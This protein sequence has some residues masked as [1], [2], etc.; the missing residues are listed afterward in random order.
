MQIVIQEVT[1]NNVKNGKGGYWVAEVTYSAN[2]KNSTKKIFSFANP[3]VYEVMSKAVQG[4]SY[5]VELKKNGEYWDWVAVKSTESA[6]VK[7]KPDVVP[8]KVI[9]SNY[10]TTEERKLRQLLIVRQSS[11]SNAIDF[12]KAQGTQEFQVMEVLGIAQQFVDFV[13]GNKD[14]FDE[15]NDLGDVPY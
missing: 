4:Q 13:Y 6:P 8:G 7:T 14:L 15:P 2:G 5:E 12:F 11:I 9:G 3:A 10:E 1:T